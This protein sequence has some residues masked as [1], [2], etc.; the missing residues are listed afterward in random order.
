MSALT[1]HRQGC[2]THLGARMHQAAGEPLCG[3]CEYRQRVLNLQAEREQPDSPDPLPGPYADLQ[4][5]IHLLAQM[6]LDPTEK[7]TAA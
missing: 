4:T 7:E 2:G 3:D 5:V 1:T 6:M